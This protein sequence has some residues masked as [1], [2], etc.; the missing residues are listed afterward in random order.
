MEPP[1]VTAAG[2]LGD[3]DP[4]VFYDEMFA[5][6]GEPRPHCVPFFDELAQMGPSQFE[7]CRRLADLAFL[8][9]GIT[10]TVYNDGLGTERLFPFDLVPRIVP[11]DEWQRIE[12]GLVQRMH[13]LNLFLADIYGTQRILDDG[14]VPAELVFGSRNFRREMIGVEVAGGIYAHV[15]VRAGA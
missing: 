14:T 1:N 8:L 15:G 2:L 4:G 10:F 13:A 3:Y 6:N 7:E 9:Q 12:R 5:S 11:A